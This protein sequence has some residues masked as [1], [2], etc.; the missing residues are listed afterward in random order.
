[1][2]DRL[3]YAASARL[4]SSLPPSL[5]APRRH[6]A[7]HRPD[8]ISRSTVPVVS[9]NYWPMARPKSKTYGRCRG[10]QIMRVLGTHT[11]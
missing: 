1:M 7:R 4:R 8:H 5:R 10:L 2:L 11:A 3:L 9:S 6:Y